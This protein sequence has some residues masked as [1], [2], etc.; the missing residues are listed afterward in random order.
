MTLSATIS[1]STQWVNFQGFEIKYRQPFVTVEIPQSGYT[2]FYYSDQSFLLPEGMEAYTFRE[3]SLG[4][5]VSQHYTTAGTVL[6]AGQA[7]VLGAQ[8]GRYTM[9]PTTKKKSLDSRNQLRGSDE[10]QLTR[11]GTFYY[12]LCEN[13]NHQMEWNWTATDGAVFKNPAHK[14]YL[15]STRSTKQ[16]SI[17]AELPSACRLYRLCRQTAAPTPRQSTIWLASK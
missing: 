17:L 5:D 14:A 9:L 15:I 3:T 4:F 1:S 2:T 16:S 12:T 11:G 6:P 10:D 13:E 8:P 7:V